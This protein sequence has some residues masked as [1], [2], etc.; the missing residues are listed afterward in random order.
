LVRKCVELFS[1]IA[2]NKEDYAKEQVP[3]VAPQQNER[4]KSGR[5]NQQRTNV[6]KQKREPRACVY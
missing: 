3:S 1:E 5:G 6:F 4:K 2:E